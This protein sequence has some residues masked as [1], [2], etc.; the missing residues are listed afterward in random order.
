MDSRTPHG[1]TRGLTMEMDEGRVLSDHAPAPSHGNRLIRVIIILLVVA[2]VLLVAALVAYIVLSSTSAFTI[3]DVKAKPTEHLTAEN[4][5]KLASID[6]ETTLLDLD[7]DA[8]TENLRRNPWVSE[9]SYVRE[10]PD[11]LTILVTERKVDAIVKMSTGSVCWCLGD[12]NVWIEPINLTVAEGQSADEASLTLAQKMGVLLIIDVPT[13]ISPTAGKDTDDDVIQAV[14]QYRAEF[15]PDFASQIVCFSASSVESVSCTLSNGVEVSLGVP[16]NIDVKEQVIKEILAKH[17]NQ[18]TYINVRVPSQ[19]TY[20]RLGV[21]SVTEGSGIQADEG[22]LA[23]SDGQQQGAE[24][25]DSQNQQ[26]DGTATD[27]QQGQDGSTDGQ[28]QSGDG[29]TQ[30]QDNSELILGD[31]GN[32]YTYEEY[33][34]I[35]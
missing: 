12:D 34:G 10:F 27:G 32:Y 13:S 31:D 21:E 17:P 1:R 4:I 30:T 16:S 22:A 2:A 19:P 11:K 5:G 20:R 9:V 25:T 18:I 26:Q 7:E 33:W 29:T 35:G 24:P 6:S 28:T 15:S 23:T 8:I 14:Q 3:R